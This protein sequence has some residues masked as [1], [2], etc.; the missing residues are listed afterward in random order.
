MIKFIGLFL[1]LF[2]FKDIPFIVEVPYEFDLPN[3]T[4]VLLTGEAGEEESARK[5]NSEKM[6]FYTAIEAMF[7]R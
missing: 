7:S 4:D 6:N 3:I 2:F 5:I 1:H